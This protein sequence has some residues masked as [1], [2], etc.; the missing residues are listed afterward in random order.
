MQHSKFTSQWKAFRTTQGH[1]T[2][3][4]W[5]N[6]VNSQ[7]STLNNASPVR[8]AFVFDCLFLKLNNRLDQ[9]NICLAIKCNNDHSANVRLQCPKTNW[10]NTETSFYCSL[11]YWSRF[12]A[13]MQAI[14]I[15]FLMNWIDNYFIHYTYF[16]QFSSV[17]AAVYFRRKKRAS[18]KEI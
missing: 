3:Y 5:N 18:N 13:G 1:T 16:M 12:R 7:T 10:F 4:V 6:F 15:R 14:P 8:L 17:Q 9:L 11:F 2:W